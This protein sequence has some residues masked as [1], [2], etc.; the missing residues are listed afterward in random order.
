MIT[1]IVT[2]VI[3]T[4]ALRTMF[5]IFTVGGLMTTAVETTA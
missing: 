1:V 5:K 2:I 3:A 4:L